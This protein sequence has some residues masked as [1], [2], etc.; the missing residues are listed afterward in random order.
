M[1]WRPRT[2]ASRDERHVAKRDLSKPPERDMKAGA[3]FAIPRTLA[4]TEA[5]GFD[6]EVTP[7]GVDDDGYSD[8]KFVCRRPPTSA[9]AQAGG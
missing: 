8:E 2:P 7:R 4:G 5:V 3:A 6:A 1:R 9:L